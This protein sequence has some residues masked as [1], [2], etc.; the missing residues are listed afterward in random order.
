MA[1]RDRRAT[2]HLVETA[3]GCCV[4]QG[5]RQ[6]L[7]ECVRR[8]LDTGVMTTSR[9]IHALLA[10]HPVVMTKA[11][12]I[13][14]RETFFRVGDRVTVVKPGDTRCGQQATVVAV[15]EFQGVIVRFQGGDG[16]EAFKFSSVAT[17]RAVTPVVDPPGSIGTATARP[18]AALV[19]TA[20][21]SSAPPRRP[22]PPPATTKI[23]LLALAAT[24]ALGK[25]GKRG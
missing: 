6:S 7:R 13:L 23:D 19:A 10:S 1:K 4:T 20:S 9:C 3:L 14:N 17:V 15:K 16:D 8:L 12:L 25:E 11:A 24:M 21:C 2:A 18:A 5:E 22:R